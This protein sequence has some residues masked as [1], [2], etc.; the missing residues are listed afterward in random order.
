MTVE[1]GPLLISYVLNPI[2][3]DK[4]ISKTNLSKFE[5]Y[6]LRL[7]TQGYEGECR[8]LLDQKGVHAK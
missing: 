4:K 3:F 1:D 2:S 6:G 8:H 7:Y 5:T